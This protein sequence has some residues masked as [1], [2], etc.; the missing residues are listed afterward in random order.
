MFNQSQYVLA[1][2]AGSYQELLDWL[3]LEVQI[4]LFSIKEN[5]LP[6]FHY[7]VIG[8]DPYVMVSSKSVPSYLQERNLKII[9]L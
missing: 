6:G 4:F 5:L 8:E 2:R 9:L 3:S 7:D 1:V